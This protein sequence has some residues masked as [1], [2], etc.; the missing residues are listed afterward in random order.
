MGSGYHSR[1]QSSEIS[2]GRCDSRQFTVPLDHSH[3]PGG[4]VGKMTE[5][6]QLTSVV[7]HGVY[8]A[9]GS[10]TSRSQGYSA[11]TSRLPL[12]VSE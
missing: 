7:S 8:E 10:T 5:W 12:P 4:K 1:D 2:L 3:Q 6:W 11:R 9:T